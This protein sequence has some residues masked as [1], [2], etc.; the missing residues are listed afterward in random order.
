MQPVATTPKIKKAVPGGSC[1]QSQTPG[2]REAS[3]EDTDIV[4]KAGWHIP[5]LVE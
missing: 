5:G 1:P 2:A 3:Q 4:A